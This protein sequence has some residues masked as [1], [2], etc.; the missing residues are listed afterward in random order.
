MEAFDRTEYIEAREV[1]AGMFMLAYEN[2]TS[3]EGINEPRQR[4]GFVRNANIWN[5]NTQMP[6]VCLSLQYATERN[7]LVVLDI[8]PILI[9][10]MEVD[11]N[12]VL[13]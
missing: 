11:P 2:R 9:A 10:Q 4:W 5:T 13:R 6:C 3:R 1:R 8:Q 7:M 12:R